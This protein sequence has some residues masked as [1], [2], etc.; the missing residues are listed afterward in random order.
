MLH[1]VEGCLEVTSITWVLVP[2][3]EVKTENPS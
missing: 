1:I 3:P 2:T